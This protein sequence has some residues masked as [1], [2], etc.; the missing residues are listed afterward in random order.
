MARSTLHTVGKY[1]LGRYRGRYVVVWNDDDGTRRRYTLAGTTTGEAR[2]A[3]DRFA[4]GQD[5]SQ[6]RT[7][8]TMS[9]LWTAYIADRTAEG[10]RSVG[11]MAHNW[12]ALAPRFG[13]LPPA[14][15]TKALCREHHKVRKASG[16]AEATI[17]TELR[18][19]RTLLSWAVKE[20]LIDKAPAV[21]MPAEPRARERWLTEDEV[22]RLIG[23]AVSPHLRLFVILALAT[24][25]RS[26]ALLTL[27]WSR[28]DLVGR[29]IMLDDPERERTAKGR[30]TVP[31]NDM[32]MAALTTAQAGA[33]TPWVIEYAHGPVKSIKKAWSG[34]IRRAG[35]EDATPH[36]LRRTAA[37]WMVMA[38]VPIEQVARYLG[39]KSPRITWATY[40]RFAPDYLRDASNAVNLD[41]RRK[42]G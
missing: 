28:V 3:L 24:A 30:A 42:V 18:R 12:K 7:A 29:R 9:A 21:W 15:V 34:A 31:I 40:G 14:M 33:L 37:S 8:D 38:G 16:I 19:I 36:D 5:L 35:I 17:L 20:E 41:L 23:A 26:E 1:R 39:H 22:R 2:Q 4:R 11:I 10:K 32:A 6:A 27:T 25:A 13:H